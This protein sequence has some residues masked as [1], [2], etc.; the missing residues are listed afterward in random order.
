[1]KSIKA[2]IACVVLFSTLVSGC[3][4][5]QL[6]GPTITP[7]GTFTPTASVTSSPTITPQPTNTPTLT[8]TPTPMIS[9]DDPINKYLS[10]VVITRADWFDTVSAENWDCPSSTSIDGMLRV[11]GGSYCHRLKFF[12]EGEG[13][14][15]SFKLDADSN[16][17][18]YFDD[19][20]G[21]W[22]TSSYKRYGY[23]T[24]SR[25][26]TEISNFI[27]AV[28]YGP[29][30]TT[31]TPETWYNLL[32]AIGEGPKFMFLIWERD[33]PG[34]QIIKT[35]VF[36]QWDEAKWKLEIGSFYGT[37]RFDYIMDLSFSEMK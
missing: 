1:M 8:S 23:A 35:G 20:L 4:P 27:G 13:V 22:G 29:R 18:F 25:T 28:G 10:N 16:F 24:G 26:G 15:V 34:N 5:G 11:R 31:P 32:L 21:E 19:R 12:K 9:L 14:L 30:I 2:I 7:T 6:F 37:V 17:E 33:N 3:G 36:P